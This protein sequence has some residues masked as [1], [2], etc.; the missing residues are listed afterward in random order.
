MAEADT[1]PS[2]RQILFEVQRPWVP[3][4]WAAVLGSAVI[5]AFCIPGMIINPDF[6][7]GDAATAKRVLGVDMNG[8]HALS[9][10]VVALPCLLAASRP[11]LATVFVVAAAVSLIVTGI[12]ALFNTYLAGGLFYF[13]NNITDAVLHLAVSTIFLAGAAHYV[14]VTRRSGA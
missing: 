13:P 7:V 5:L 3:V 14:L 12:R 1:R 10:F 8:W 2:T 9:G 4:Q 6:A 11:A